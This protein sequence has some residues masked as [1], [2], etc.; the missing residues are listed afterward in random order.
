MSSNE[1]KFDGILLSMA[2]EHTGGV[3]E[4]LETFFS[5]LCRKTDFYFGAEG[6]AAEKLVTDTFRKYQDISRK[7]NEEKTKEREEVERRERQKREQR[8]RDEEAA[9]KANASQPQ[10]PKIVELTDEEADRLQK[11]ISAGKT[12]TAATAD[13]GD[14]LTGA[15]SASDS[16]TDTNGTDGK[17]DKADD[18]DEDE[19]DKGKLKPNA[20]NGCDLPDYTWTQTL[21][22]LE[23]RVPLRVAFKLR[24]RDIVVEYKKRHLKV[25]VKGQ[26]PVIDGELHNE[27]KVD[28]C[29]WVLQDTNTAVITLEKCHQMEWWPRL[30]V[31]DPEMNTRKVNPE[32][33]KLSDLDGETRSMVEKMM[34]DQRQKEMGLPTS[35][36]QKKQDVIKKFMVDHPEMDFT[37][38][39]FT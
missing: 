36:D 20:G 39:K 29:C 33:S 9:I 6:S 25:G 11:Q 18:D 3:Q 5:F 38:C 17:G 19:A 2:R 32:A 26:P 16:K 10:Q 27:I 28:D 34:Y 13:G 37:N 8:R 12:G 24:A 7:V 31:T 35:E 14:K 1:D 22:E 21:S 4:L 23:V 30:Q 15:D